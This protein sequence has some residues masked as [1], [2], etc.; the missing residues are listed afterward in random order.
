MA[1]KGRIS[2]KDLDR[3]LK[4]KLEKVE[5]LCSDDHRSYSTFAKSNTIKHKKFNAS[6]EQRAVDKVYNVNN[7]DIR[8]RK[9]MNSFNGVATKYLQN[10]LNGS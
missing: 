4:G 3:I 10:N 2:K 1:T 7:M 6:K 5:I 9:F 8:L